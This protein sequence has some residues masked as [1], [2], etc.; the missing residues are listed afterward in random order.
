MDEF[1]MLYDEWTSCRAEI[2][3]KN[4]TARDMA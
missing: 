3:E 1:S 2:S 4:Y